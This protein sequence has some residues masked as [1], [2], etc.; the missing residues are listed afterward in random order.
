[1]KKFLLVAVVLLCVNLS[2][3]QPANDECSSA[4]AVAATTTCYPPSIYSNGGSTLSTFP[5]PFCGQPVGDT[6]YSFVAVSDSYNV[7]VS[8]TFPSNPNVAGFYSYAVGVY[9][10]TCGALTYI[11]CNGATYMAGG[12]DVPARVS[13]SGLTVGDTYYVRVQ[14]SY[15][16]SNQSTPEPNQI[17]YHL[18]ILPQLP[19]PV[20]D[21]CSGAITLEQVT[22][23]NGNN[24]GAT[25]DDLTGFPV[26]GIATN[27]K[28]K[29]L[30]YT[31]T[32]L[33]NGDLNFSTCGSYFDTYLKVFSGGTC[34]LPTTCVAS[35]DNFC[36]T[37]ADVTISA[38]AGTTYY[39]LMGSRNPGE[40]GPFS[41]YAFGFGLEL[42]VTMDALA[43]KVIAG[44]KA[45]LNWNTYKEQNNKGFEVQR[46][47]DGKIF[48]PAGFVAS[49]GNEGNSTEK[50]AYTFTDPMA[51]ESAVFYRL[52]QTDIDGKK[53][54]S[55]IIRL[56]TEGA[57]SFNL[58]ATPNPVKDRLSVRAY[59]KTGK[60]AYLL[61]TDMNGRVL[62][63]IPVTAETTEIDMSAL[64][65]GIY[66]VKYI[67]ENCTQIL[68]I[69]KQ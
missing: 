45:S 66:L 15:G 31:V 55:N 35:N 3:A 2:Y 61:L 16:W 49:K 13:L 41:I 17:I 26:C 39:I 43:G 38:V 46:S 23:I 37:S 69:N 4:I 33:S 34:P 42:P 14:S 51:I 18:C 20:N 47:V 19:Q 8:N 59:G 60:H 24:N 32:A 53:D 40:F 68:K 67:D 64:A 36:T 52:Q 54:Y 11:A 65:K 63:H 56:S 30:W 28:Y 12:P 6:W 27:G 1:M 57:S 21:S 22:P 7:I 50:I 44:N 48:I 5:G 9:S 58:V 29:G 10:G 25:D 62:Q